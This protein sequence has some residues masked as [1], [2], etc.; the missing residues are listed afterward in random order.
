[1]NFSLSIAL[2]PE[3]CGGISLYSA[4]ILMLTVSPLAL[5]LSS[6]FPFYLFIYHCIFWQICLY[7]LLVV[8]LLFVGYCYLISEIIFC[9]YGGSCHVSLGY[10]YDTS[11]FHHCDQW[12]FPLWSSDPYSIIVLC[13]HGP[14]SSHCTITVDSLSTRDIFIWVSLSLFDL[15]CPLLM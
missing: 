9:G 2:L 13:I 12:H 1:M 8:C 5:Y 15:G 6:P 10:G 7:V 3:D 4:S 11:Y 14:L